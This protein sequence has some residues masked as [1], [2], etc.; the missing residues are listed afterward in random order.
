MTQQTTIK[1]FSINNQYI[2][3]INFTLIYGLS[4]AI[5]KLTSAKKHF[6]K[7]NFVKYLPKDDAY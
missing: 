2:L 4:A 3:T 1:Y 6:T 5:T 7:F